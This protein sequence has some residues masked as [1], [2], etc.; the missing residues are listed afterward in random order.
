MEEKDQDMPLEI[1]NSHKS[2]WITKDVA[3]HLELAEN[4]AL[5][6]QYMSRLVKEHPKWP[7]CQLILSKD[8]N[9]DLFEQKLEVFKNSMQIGIS[10]FQKYLV[11]PHDV[12]LLVIFYQKTKVCLPL[13]IGHIFEFNE[14]N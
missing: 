10:T 7:N 6:L 1:R 5:S 9:D 2:N 12:L 11:E 14:I 3:Y 4:L 13:I 8:C